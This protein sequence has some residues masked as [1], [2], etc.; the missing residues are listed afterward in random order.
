V[1]IQISIDNILS[2]NNTLYPRHLSNTRTNN[3]FLTL[4][5]NKEFA[6]SCSDQTGRF[7]IPSSRG[8]KYVS[9]FYDYDANATLAT[10]I[11]NRQCST[12]CEAWVKAY[13]LIV[14]QSEKGIFCSFVGWFLFWGDVESRGSCVVF[15]FCR[16]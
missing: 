6:R 13:M 2:I 3:V 5:D 14:D 12:I 16:V 7:P 4:I 1:W 11:L 8:N 9:I 10:A 15:G